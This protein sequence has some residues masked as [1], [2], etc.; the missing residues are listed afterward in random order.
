MERLK[1]YRL[2]ANSSDKIKVKKPVEDGDY[3]L[4]STSRQIQ[5]PLMLKGSMQNIEPMTSTKTLRKETVQIIDLEK[6][7]SEPEV[8]VETEPAC[9]DK[10]NVMQG[11]AEAPQNNSGELSENALLGMINSAVLVVI[12]VVLVML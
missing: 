8:E 1:I 11:P 7:S 3:M 5:K 2:A 10:S 6:P 4:P 9:Q 12:L